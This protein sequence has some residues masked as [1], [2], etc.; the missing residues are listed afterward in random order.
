MTRWRAEETDGANMA[1]ST[2]DVMREKGSTHFNRGEM[3]C[4][5]TQLLSEVER[6]VGEVATMETKERNS[7]EV[8]VV[9]T[10]DVISRRVTFNY[11]TITQ[12]EME[13]SRKWEI[14]ASDEWLASDSD[15]ESQ[16]SRNGVEP[17][18]LF[19]VTASTAPLFQVGATSNERD[20]TSHRSRINNAARREESVELHSDVTVRSPYMETNFQQSI[21]QKKPKKD[22]EQ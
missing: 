8:V 18:P 17:R 16:Q 22:T 1:S 9:V 4:L 7:C 15:A 20:V 2:R 14:G 19:A 13:V 6:A 10:Q 21:V 12:V 11:V 3:T 5:K